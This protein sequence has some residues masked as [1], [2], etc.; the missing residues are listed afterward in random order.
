MKK[1]HIKHFINELQLH[2]IYIFVQMK[3]QD[4]E[5]DHVSYSN[6]GENPTSL[7]K[8]LKRRVKKTNKEKIEGASTTVNQFYLLAL[9]GGFE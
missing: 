5:S 8:I 6:I 3:M 4:V 1:K 7:H 9:E 2:T